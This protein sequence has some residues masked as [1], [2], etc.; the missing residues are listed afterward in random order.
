VPDFSPGVTFF[1]KPAT[2]LPPHLWMVISRPTA[3]GHVL[4]VNFTE[5]KDDG[6]V[7]C[8]IDVGE[9]P[10]IKKRTSVRYLSM[11]AVAPSVLADYEAK[12][13]VCRRERL[14]AAILARVRT[15]A[16]ESP[17]CKNAFKE[18]LRGDGAA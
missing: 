7:T 12:G 18:I 17:L 5:Y 15:G 13:L 6:D 2:G 1:H 3:K 9:H 14:S 4:I 16:L 10:F 11:R 8:T